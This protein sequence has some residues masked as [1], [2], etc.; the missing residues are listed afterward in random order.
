MK[1]IIVRVRLPN[2]LSHCTH[3]R[4]EVE[5]EA[6]TLEECLGDL[7]GR[8]PLLKVHLFDEKNKIRRHVNIFYNDK[9]LKRLADWSIPLIEGD[10][11]TVL[12]AVSG[13]SCREGQ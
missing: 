1:K 11:V 5:V 12:Q 9:S 6:A 4:R 13:G 8:Y 2:I 10:T 7:F 3:G